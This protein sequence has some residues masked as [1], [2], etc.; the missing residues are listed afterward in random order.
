MVQIIFLHEEYICSKT[1]YVLV[2]D[3]DPNL[4]AAVGV[5]PTSK[6]EYLGPDIGT[7]MFPGRSRRQAEPL[8][9]VSA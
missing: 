1:C 9:R 4:I 2:S 8:L 7:R 3:H 6:A 5:D